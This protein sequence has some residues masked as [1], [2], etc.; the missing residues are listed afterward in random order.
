M[1]LLESRIRLWAAGRARREDL[2]AAVAAA[3]RDGAPTREVKDYVD[4]RIAHYR[5][6]PVRP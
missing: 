3:L 5:A 2:L 1:V 4:R 6:A